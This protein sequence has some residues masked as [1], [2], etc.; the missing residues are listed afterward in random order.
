MKVS[1]DCQMLTFN[2][3]EYDWLRSLQRRKRWDWPAVFST[4]P[5][6]NIWPYVRHGWTPDHEREEVRGLSTVIDK[7]ADIYLKVRSDGGRLFIDD[8]LACYKG[9]TVGD[10]PTVFVIFQIVD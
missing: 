2:R 3:K 6:G 4:N 1:S 9:E 10:E 8:Q 7:V 5:K